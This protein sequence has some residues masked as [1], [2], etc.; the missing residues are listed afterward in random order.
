[1]KH[2][3]SLHNQF[4]LQ[5]THSIEKWACYQRLGQN[6]LQSSLCAETHDPLCVPVLLYHHTHAVHMTTRYSGG[7]CTTSTAGI[8]ASD[9]SCAYL[10]CMI[11][12]A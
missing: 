12:T 8:R 9:N 6:D 11:N 1:M 7:H 2:F 5:Q 10:A 3:E 4:L